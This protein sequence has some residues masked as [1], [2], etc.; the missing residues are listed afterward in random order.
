MAGTDL[1]VRLLVCFNPGGTISC[2]QCLNDTLF[3]DNFFNL[4]VF[5]FTLK[6]DYLTVIRNLNRLPRAGAL[7]EDN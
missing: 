5:L 6:A 4:G 2:R 1:V 3:T 7:E